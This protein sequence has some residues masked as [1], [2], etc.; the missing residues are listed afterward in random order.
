M[1]RRADAPVLEATAAAFKVN[2]LTMEPRTGLSHLITS[3]GALKTVPIG[4]WDMKHFVGL[5]ALP[6]VIASDE[7]SVKVYPLFS[8]FHLFLS[9]FC[10]CLYNSA[11]GGQTFVL[12]MQN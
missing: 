7:H 5:R 4:H 1:S 11:H 10:C 2:I 9:D 6:T 12:L 8:V 3:S